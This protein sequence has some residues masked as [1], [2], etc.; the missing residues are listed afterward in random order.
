MTWKLLYCGVVLAIYVSF[1]AFIWCFLTCCVVLRLLSLVSAPQIGR[2]TPIKGFY[3]SLRVVITKR[4]C[5][6]SRH[7]CFPSC[8]NIPFIYYWLVFNNEG[9]CSPEIPLK[10]NMTPAREGKDGVNSSDWLY[11]YPVALGGSFDCCLEMNCES[12]GNRLNLIWELVW[13]CQARFWY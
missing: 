8:R 7:G 2:K 5:L 10:T 9:F 1:S 3:F 13:L 4:K 12:R 6:P 11:V